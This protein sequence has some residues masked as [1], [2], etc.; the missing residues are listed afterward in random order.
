VTGRVNTEFAKQLESHK[1]QLELAADSARFDFQRR[2]SE[3]N[4]YASKK[5]KIAAQVYEKVRIAHGRI[6]DVTGLSR[7]LTFEEFDVSDISEHMTSLGF[8]NGKREEIVN[9]WRPDR[10]AA[11]D[12][13][14]PYLRMLKIQSAERSLAEAQNCAY[15]GELYLSDQIIEKLNSLLTELT[16]RLAT[17]QSQSGEEF[18]RPP[19]QLATALES[20]RDTFHA[21]LGGRDAPASTAVERDR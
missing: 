13:L 4:I 20:L 14:R 6:I 15:S 12:K 11:L 19:E 3:F 1:H 8:P 18:E 21:E 2:L 5:H 9:L 17:V 10:A 16:F 7:E